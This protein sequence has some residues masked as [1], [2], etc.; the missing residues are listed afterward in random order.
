M[1][2][3]QKR[4][5]ELIYNAFITLLSK[6]SYEKITV[7][8][9]IEKANVGR[10]TFYSHFETKE[11]LL[12]GLCEELFAHIFETEEKGSSTHNHVFDCDEKTSVFLHLFS[13]FENNDN[14]LCKLF[15]CQSAEIFLKYFSEYLVE[16]IRKNQ[17]EIFDK[18]PKNVP[19]EFWVYHVSS[20]FILTVNWWI[21]NKMKQSKEEITEYF[22]SVL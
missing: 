13:H 15:T 10:A 6:K 14:N 8:E 16:L 9:I 2:R 5:R 7:G 1:D 21:K 18:K 19:E 17:G 11:F 20:T 12:K 3:R 22:L 4:T